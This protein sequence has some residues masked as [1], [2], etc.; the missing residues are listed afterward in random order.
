RLPLRLGSA[1][2]VSTLAGVRHSSRCG[3]TAR[4]NAYPDAA[5]PLP[6]AGLEGVALCQPLCGRGGWADSFVRPCPRAFPLLPRDHRRDPS[7]PT[8]YSSC[9]SQVLRS[10]RTSAARR[11]TSP[12]AYTSDLVATTTAQSDLPCSALLLQRVLRP[13]PRGDLV[14]VVLRT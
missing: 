11:S 13:L 2:L 4:E 9:R 12:S 8:R 6:S 1:S 3:R 10:P 5:W 7:L 14:L